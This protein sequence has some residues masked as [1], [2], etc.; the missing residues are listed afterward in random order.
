[1]LQGVSAMFLWGR[2]GASAG[3]GQGQGL[4]EGFLLESW[5]SCRCQLLNEPKG[6]IPSR[7]RF[8]FLS[9]YHSTGSILSNS[10]PEGEKWSN[11]LKAGISLL[12]EEEQP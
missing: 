4:P 7:N 10:E 12:R 5:R 8:S 11:I 2:G 6:K 3:G 9:L 1:M